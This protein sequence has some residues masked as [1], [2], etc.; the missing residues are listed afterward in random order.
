M[1]AIKHTDQHRAS[2]ESYWLSSDSTAG[3]VNQEKERCFHN[4]SISRRKQTNIAFICAS[5]YY[6]CISTFLAFTKQR[7]I[8]VFLVSMLRA[9]NSYSHF[10]HANRKWLCGVRASCTQLGCFPNVQLPKCTV[11]F[12]FNV[13]HVKIAF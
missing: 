12:Y 10:S 8:Q 1:C 4:L 6:K 13:N 3:A 7:F 9:T 11:N 5:L 2:S